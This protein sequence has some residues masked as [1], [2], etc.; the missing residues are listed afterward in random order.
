M[1]YQKAQNDKQRKQQHKS[2]V[3]PERSALFVRAVQQRNRQRHGVIDA[4][5]DHQA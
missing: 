4:E 1:S 2:E 3:F 5:R